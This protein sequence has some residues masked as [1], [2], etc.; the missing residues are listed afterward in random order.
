MDNLT[1]VVA[2]LAAAVVTV[3]LLRRLQLPDVVAYLLVG[4]AAGPAGF[5]LVEDTQQILHLAEYGIVFLLFSL[6]LEF[7]IPRLLALRRIVLGAGPIQVL[8]I[9]GLVSI[10]MH[11]L[12]F[13][14][15]VALVTGGALALS[16]TAIVIRELIARGEVNTRYGRGA[17]GILLFQDLAAV[18]MLVLL[19]ALALPDGNPLTESALM[20]GKSVLLFAGIYVAGKWMLP[21]LL[22]ETVRTRSSEVFLMTALLLALLAA[23]V[24]QALGLSMALGAFLAG[25]ML[26]ESQFRH[27]IEA[28]IRPFRD[29][30]LGLFFISVGMLVD[31]GLV[32]AH[33]YWIFLAALA[34]LLTKGL[35]ISLLLRAL[36][37]TGESA[38]RSGIVLAQAGEFGFVL[39]T[40]AVQHQLVTTE[41]A[42]LVISIIVVTMALT[43]MLVRH[44]EA[45]AQA[46]MARL[47]TRKAP[48]PD[49]AEPPADD[50]DHVILC[51]YGRVGQILGRYFNRFDLPWLAI[52]ADLVRVE[53]A[54]A[55]GEHILFGDASHNGIL[56]K[57]G[58]HQASLLVITFEDTR[59]A[60]KILHSVRQ[61]RAD[62][63]VLVRT[64][65]ETHLETLHEAG[66]TEV[67]PETLEASLMLASQAL[68]LLDRP[69]D[70]VLNTL[71][72]SRRERYQ[73]LRG[74]YHGENFPR[75]DS[76]GNPYQLLRAI[77]VDEQSRCTDRRLDDTGLNELD[78][79][80]KEIKREG[81]SISE[82]GPDFELHTGDIV[83]VYGPLKTLEKAE[84]KL[85]GG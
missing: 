39:I 62:I 12:G 26:G 66:A 38:A 60:G 19:P 34:L 30:L 50:H 57:S 13:A 45:C 21:P 4:L 47:R 65:D 71:R 83:I 63:K 32:M 46:L 53:E 84:H 51:G 69:F 80:V 82:P 44:S 42:G 5:A 15:A 49:P 23:W 17:T 37:G 20:L 11:L 7:S 40:L 8:G 52:D 35:L 24:T 14:P 78:L 48:T 68:L 76:E 36:G 18:I 28:D 81:H 79:E 59:L 77:T 27:Q 72:Q 70:E 31:P 74:Y 33:W 41:Q 73:L 3:T 43:P 2:L 25:M 22:A 54:S 75:I 61:L 55:A 9:G 67:V 64:R 1:L 58:I 6:G 16:S 10:L 29:L 85:L 56:V